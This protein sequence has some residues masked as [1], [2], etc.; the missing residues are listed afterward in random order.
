MKN[1]P[2]GTLPAGLLLPRLQLFKDDLA[3]GFVA[4]RF[5]KRSVLQHVFRGDAQGRHIYRTSRRQ[6]ARQI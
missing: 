3:G 2:A 6:P 5:Q 4:H 1:R